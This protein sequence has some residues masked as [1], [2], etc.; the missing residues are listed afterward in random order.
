M[1]SNF[2]AF[3]ENLMGNLRKLA[4]KAGIGEVAKLRK[5]YAEIKKLVL[6]MV[7]GRPTDW[8]HVNT[9]IGQYYNWRVGPN[10]SEDFGPDKLLKLKQLK[11]EMDELKKQGMLLG[12]SHWELDK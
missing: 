7:N 8:R 3:H 5:R 12:L 2:N 6:K 1:T 9:P 4:A 10:R 11:Q